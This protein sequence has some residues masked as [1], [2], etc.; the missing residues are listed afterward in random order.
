MDFIPFNSSSCNRNKNSSPHTSKNSSQK[1]LGVPFG[2][3]ATGMPAFGSPAL[4]FGAPSIQNNSYNP[5]KGTPSP[6]HYNQQFSPRSNYP[7]MSPRPFQHNQS[8][9]GR[10]L[11]FSPYGQKDSHRQSNQSSDSFRLDSSGFK[12]PHQFSPNYRGRGNGRKSIGRH[13]GQTPRLDCNAGGSLN[14]E[15][16]YHPSMLEDPWRS[17]NPVFIKT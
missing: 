13:F 5:S 7:N 4:G 10:N 1:T 3:P 6:R 14:P 12:T 8:P 9:R 15:D 16:Y 11:Q 2:S 17:L